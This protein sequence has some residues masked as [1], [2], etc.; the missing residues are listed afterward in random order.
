[1]TRPP[2]TRS[3]TGRAPSTLAARAAHLIRKRWQ[4]YW[5]WRARQATILILRSLDR[6]TLHDIGIAPSE[7]ESLVGACGDD[8]RPRYDPAWL[9]RCGRASTSAARAKRG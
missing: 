4:A 1:M 2:S 3:S 9:S 7:I 8:R 6:R 5:E